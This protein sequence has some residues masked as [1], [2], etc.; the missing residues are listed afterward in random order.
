MS[1]GAQ[2][3]AICNKNLNIVGYQYDHIITFNNRYNLSIEIRYR[4]KRGYLASFRLQRE[5]DNLNAYT[6]TTNSLP[7]QFGSLCY[8]GSVAYLSLIHTSLLFTTACVMEPSGALVNT[9]R[10]DW[11][12]VTNSRSDVA[13]RLVTS[14]SCVI[15]RW[16][17]ASAT[18]AI[19]S[20]SPSPPFSWYLPSYA[21]NCWPVSWM[22]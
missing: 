13:K 3:Q 1:I 21:F 6:K 12:S 20:A 8:M 4:E 9:T 14:F 10:E 7:G 15:T 22:I 5:P 16:P 19:S 2:L 18:V 11:S 17:S